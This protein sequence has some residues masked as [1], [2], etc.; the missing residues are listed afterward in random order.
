MRARVKT[1]K[2]EC[3]APS[4]S[5]SAGSEAYYSVCSHPQLMV[6]YLTKFSFS[7]TFNL[8]TSEE[9]VTSSP[10]ELPTTTSQHQS[11][12]IY[13]IDN[14][15]PPLF[16]PNFVPPFYPTMHSFTP[17]SSTALS[18]PTTDGNFQ[19]M[20]TE[21][22][23]TMSRQDK[24]VELEKQL[25]EAV[26]ELTFFGDRNWRMEA[27]IDCL[28]HTLRKLDVTSVIDLN[29]KMVSHLFC[30]KGLFLLIFCT[31]A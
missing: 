3:T 26:R 29:Q 23:T 18:I 11:I 17:Q 27:Y 20:V 21:N 25:K 31:V 8:R 5:M 15:P 13:P 9:A 30:T 10:S 19:P 16:Q 24:V 28:V 6:D 7:F 4:T 12:V 14:S 2:Q 1:P 22:G